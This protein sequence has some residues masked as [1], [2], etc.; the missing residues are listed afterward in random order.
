MI[1]IFFLKPISVLKEKLF[2]K[3][4]SVKAGFNPCL[5]FTAMIY[6]DFCH[7]KTL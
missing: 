3:P 6:K 5:K 7:L 1:S 2:L 4:F